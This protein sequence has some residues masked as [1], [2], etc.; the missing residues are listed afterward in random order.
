MLPPSSQS[1]SLVWNFNFKYAPQATVPKINA[2]INVYP[3]IPKV[4]CENILVQFHKFTSHIRQKILKTVCRLSLPRSTSGHVDKSFS[5]NAT[6]CKVLKLDFFSL[7]SPYRVMRLCVAALMMFYNFFLDSL[8]DL[9][10]G[11][12]E[13][14]PHTARNFLNFMQ[15]FGNFGNIVCWRPPWMVG[16]PSYGNPGSAPGT[17]VLMVLASGH[18]SKM[19]YITLFPITTSN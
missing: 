14:A 6:Y 10:G 3:L 12:R 17:G 2:L 7:R 8:A 5:G 9:G 18:L 19:I 1:F 13:R 15:F 11:C 4:T 16:A